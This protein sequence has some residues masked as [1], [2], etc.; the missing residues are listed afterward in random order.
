MLGIVHRSLMNNLIRQLVVDL[1]NTTTID[2]SN[3]QTIDGST[4]N[5]QTYYDPSVNQTIGA[6]TSTSTSSMPLES[7]I[8]LLVIVFS[9]VIGISVC[10]WV[11]I[12]AYRFADRR[13]SRF[14][15]SIVPS[16]YIAT[17]STSVSQTG[18]PKQPRLTI[19]TSH[20][21][22]AWM[23]TTNETSSANEAVV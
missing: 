4:L 8:N 18:L 13:P 14:N 17:P 6:P 5:N 22:L 20:S 19:H 11:V 9:I 23:N 10:F 15:T 16:S 21:S 1:S 2:Q 3:N 12:C 7:S